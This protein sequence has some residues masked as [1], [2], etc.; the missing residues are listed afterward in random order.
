MM[1]NAT[2]DR[3]RSLVNLVEQLPNVNYLDLGSQFSLLDYDIDE[4]PYYV[5]AR[6][7][8]NPSLLFTKD[9]AVLLRSAKS[10]IPLAFNIYLVDCQLVELELFKVDSSSIDYSSFWNNNQKLLFEVTWKIL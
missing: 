10:E 6:H 9:I 8:G 1:R 3:L 5:I 4:T 7:K 2:F